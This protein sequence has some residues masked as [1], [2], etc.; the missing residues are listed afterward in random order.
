MSTN[1]REAAEGI[2]QHFADLGEPVGA[3]DHSTNRWGGQ[4]SYFDIGGNLRVR[5]SDHGCNTD[6]RVQEVHVP[7]DATRETVAAILAEI[8][9]KTE[10]HRQKIAARNV[11]R[12]A[13]EA[14]FRV[15]WA[16]A[17]DRGAVV[18]RC[19]PHLGRADRQDVAR[20]WAAT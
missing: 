8:E 6:F 13:Y 10:A 9:A 12:D 2:R 20:R 19:Y 18:A 4:S 11:E 1:I 5:V 7:V 17:K 16:T 3:I 15:E 14:P